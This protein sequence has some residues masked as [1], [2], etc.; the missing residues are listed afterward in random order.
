MKNPNMTPRHF[1]FIASTIRNM[2]TFAASLR[3]QRESCAAAFADALA[4]THSN[5]DRDR[6]IADATRS[7]KN[8]K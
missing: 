7:N 5:F 8:G 4:K 2:P 6:F 3:T 1:E